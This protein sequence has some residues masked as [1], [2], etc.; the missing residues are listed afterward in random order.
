MLGQKRVGSTLLSRDIV[1][2]ALDLGH[3][4]VREVMRPRREITALSTEDSIA[5]CLDIAEKTRYSRFPLCKGGEL[6][7]TLGVVHTKDLF[8][9]RMRARS[10]EDL[11]PVARK[12]IYVPETA[13]LEALPIYP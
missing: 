6:D 11:I 7:K 8:A 2:N 4:T 13:G 10:G 3:R 5:Q 12:L 1:L 9:V